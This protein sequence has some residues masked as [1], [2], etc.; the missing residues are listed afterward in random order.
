[1][2]PLGETKARAA[3]SA[4]ALPSTPR[5]LS[6]FEIKAR[7]PLSG[8]RQ[9]HIW[10]RVIRPFFERFILTF[11]IDLLFVAVSIFVVV[12]GST[13]INQLRVEKGTPI[14]E[15]L[16][17]AWILGQEIPRLLAGFFA[18]YLVYVVAFL[19]CAGGT[20]GAI[21]IRPAVKDPK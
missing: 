2:S 10:T 3:G 7:A 8:K 20:L 9:I 21:S 13:L 14:S 11:G 12:L 17:L 6:G 16:P 4:P 15:V 5:V 18:V 1:M 19:V